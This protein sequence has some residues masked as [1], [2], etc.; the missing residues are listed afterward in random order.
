MFNLNNIYAL[1]RDLIALVLI[2][3]NCLQLLNIH[4]L[5]IC[6]T[7]AKKKH[8]L[9]NP[10]TCTVQFHVYIFCYFPFNKY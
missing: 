2:I 4:F 10:H 3:K 8:D 5:L 9:Y 6:S 7:Y 1:I